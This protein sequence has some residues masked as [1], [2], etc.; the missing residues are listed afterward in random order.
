[1]LNS[2][3][4]ISTFDSD[5]SSWDVSK[6]TTMA[7]MVSLVEEKKKE[8]RRKGFLNAYFSCLQ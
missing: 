8:R 1:M 4:S 3:V 2:E 6:A 7:K 5:L